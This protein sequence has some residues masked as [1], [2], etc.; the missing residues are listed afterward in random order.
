MAIEKKLLLFK[1]AV[2]RGRKAHNLKV[3]ANRRR[4]YNFLTKEGKQEGAVL[5]EP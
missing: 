2:K 3:E 5:S 1:V 4:K